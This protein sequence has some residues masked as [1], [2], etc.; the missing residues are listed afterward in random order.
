M[1]PTGGAAVTRQLDMTI[2]LSVLTYYQRMLG[3]SE[4]SRDLMLC[5]SRTLDTSHVNRY[6]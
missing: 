2:P 3:T 1:I 4:V 6:K 5:K